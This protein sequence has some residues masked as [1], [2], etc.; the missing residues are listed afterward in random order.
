[1]AT[2][3]DEEA[4]TAQ[5]YA[6]CLDP[7]NLRQALEYT[8]PEAIYD[9]QANDSEFLVVWDGAEFLELYVTRHCVFQVLSDSTAIVTNVLSEYCQ[10]EVPGGP[11]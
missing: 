11:E 10:L 3:Y 9:L 4:G 1:M 2:D 6:I 8:V 7:E 5:V